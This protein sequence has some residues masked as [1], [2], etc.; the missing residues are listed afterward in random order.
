MPVVIWFLIF[1]LSPST[2]VF[3]GGAKESLTYSEFLKKSSQEPVRFICAKFNTY[4]IVLLGEHHRIKQQVDFVKN[5]IRPLKTAGVSVLVLEFGDYRLQPILDGLLNANTFDKNKVNAILKT[6]DKPLGWGYQEYSDIFEEV[7]KTN[8]ETQTARIKILLGN[9]EL[10]N[11]EA[12][13]TAI[14]NVWNVKM[15]H[16]QFGNTADCKKY[17]DS[18]SEE[19]GGFITQNKENIATAFKKLQ[20]SQEEIKGVKIAELAGTAYLQG[21]KV[22]IYAGRN[23]LIAH[24]NKLR[25]YSSGWLLNHRYPGKVYSIAFRSTERAD[26]L[27]E[28]EVSAN[29]RQ[30]IAF[31]LNT[32]PFGSLQFDDKFKMRDAWDGYIFLCP[33]EDYLPVTVI[34][35]FFGTHESERKEFLRKQIAAFK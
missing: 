20:D 16:R 19:V 28:K 34:P 24:T 9:Y 23:H 5:L 11:D 10:E 8:R 30:P 2:Y 12:Q 27:I 18:H 3:A 22:L 7:W 31:P 15:P 1:P 13:W 21:S 14:L 26:N 35:G 25:A 29:T 17:A 4:P 32:G 33:K 6:V